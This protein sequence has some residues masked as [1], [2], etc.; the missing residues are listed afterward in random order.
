[1]LFNFF[2]KQSTSDLNSRAIIQGNKEISYKELID[3]VKS[4]S[5]YFLNEGI[6]AND[7]A[8]IL[9]ENNTEFIITILSLWN[10]GAVPIPLNIKLSKKELR[11]QIN[12]SK[13]KKLISIKQAK[14][15]KFQ[16]LQTI[17][18]LSSFNKITSNFPLKN[19]NNLNN[20]AVIIF[21][22]G[23][24]GNPKGVMLSFGNLDH[25]AVNCNEI[26]NQVKTDR[27][28]ASLPF[29]HIGGFSIIVRALL[30]GA[31]I[32]IPNSLKTKDLASSLKKDKP[33]SASFVSTQLK[34]LIEKNI[35]PNKELK[36]IL[37][38]GGFVGDD[39]L[40]NAIKKGWKIIKVYG[41]TETASLVTA[42]P[43][44]KIKN[45]ISSSGKPLNKNEI[46]IIGEKSRNLSKGK[47]G[48]I[49]IKSLS[50]MKCYLNN[51]KETNR[52]LIN[53]YYHSGDIGYLDEDGYLFVESRRNDLIISGGENIN[54]YEVENEILKNKSVEEV[55]IVGLNDVEWGQ[56][57]AAAIVIKIG[58]K[59]NEKNLKESLKKNLAAYKIP[60][61]IIF[62][63][64][65]PKS[66]LGKIQKEKLKKLFKF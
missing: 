47:S 63:D 59:I 45:K 23:S 22:S 13:C 17:N 28:L 18:F 49:L 36:N 5:A 33:T 60:K 26:L 24:S 21:T 50:V 8:A 27:W 38:G 46:K 62:V 31:S 34:R 19:K 65:L 14:K 54:P 42:L 2:P 7:K 61:K 3:K 40:N 29:Y 48:E 25:S 20:T 44:D 16:N 58:K 32:I 11:D 39:L 10:I 41:S 6:K 57:A 4:V 35:N 52:K 15:I 30:F 9:S 12:F 37:L 53:G 66:T 43:F 55:S 51:K 1:M 56:I 64:G